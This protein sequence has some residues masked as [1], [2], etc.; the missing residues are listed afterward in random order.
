MF[1]CVCVCECVSVCA[2]VCVSVCVRVCV[3]L[4]R[5]LRRAVERIPLQH[6]P[7][8]VQQPHLVPTLLEH[9]QVLPV[10]VPCGRDA[11][12]QW[13]ERRTPE[14]KIRVRFPSGLMNKFY[15]VECWYPSDTNMMLVGGRKG[16]S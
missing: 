13:V 2:C 11:V 4:T 15:H 16:E 9:R 8:W 12:A 3:L 5:T 6:H 1:I 7:L 14:P 10:R